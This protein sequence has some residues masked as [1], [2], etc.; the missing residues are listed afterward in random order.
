MRIPTTVT[1]PMYSRVKVTS[2]QS[3]YDQ[4]DL[5]INR[6]EPLVA[7]YNKCLPL[8]PLSADL[9][10]HDG[11]SA[12]E[13]SFDSGSLRIA[14][15]R[16]IRV[17]EGKEQ[18]NLPPGLGAFP[19]YNVAEFAHVL[20]QDMVEKGGLFFAMYRKFDQFD[21]ESEFSYRLLNAV[22]R[23]AM[24]LRFTSNKQFAIRIYIGGVNAITGE[25]MIPNMAT[26]LKRQNGIGKKQDYVV[27]PEQPWLDGIATSPGV[28]K[29]FVA[30]PYGSG[31]SIEHQVDVSILV[32]VGL[33]MSKSMK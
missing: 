18:N 15:Q 30:V 33:A 22:E 19:L 23:E 12:S 27:V 25:P 6:D 2:G 31:Y 16:T 7:F 26:L 17:P 32:S 4:T 9:P 21:R 3:S 10:R 20:P 28:V 11:C 5:Q 14:F 24:W 8:Q 1:T 13:L 29:Q